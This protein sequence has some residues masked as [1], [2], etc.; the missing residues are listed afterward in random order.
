MKSIEITRIKN[1]V[2]EL[3]AKASFEL[4]TDITGAIKYSLD[5][6]TGKSAKEVLRLILE[7]ADSAKS[8]KLPLCQDCGN[9][10]INLKIG[11]GIC[12][13]E[14]GE[15]Q[16]HLDDAVADAY[17]KNYLRKSIVTDPLYSRANTGYNTPA[18]ITI[19]LVKEPGLKIEVSLKG[20]GS[21]NCSY[22]KMQNP[23]INENDIMKL[24]VDLVR[25]NVTKCCPPVILGVGIGGTASVVTK[26]A[27]QAAFRDL[28]IRNSDKRYQMLEQKILEAVNNTGIGPQ[29]LGG[30][31]TAIGCNIEFAPCHIATLPAA[32][33]IQC[34]SL[35]RASSKISPP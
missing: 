8:Q 22:L 34:H 3:I 6:E 17:S 30:M 14:S 11:P 24:V 1:K 5:A 16:K 20:G 21:E 26:M 35:R 15:L 23:S 19:E 31:T 27:R 25:A 2:A 33:F 18:L 28:G 29:G 7:N 9:T 32:V 13:A 4:P 10:Y 12:I